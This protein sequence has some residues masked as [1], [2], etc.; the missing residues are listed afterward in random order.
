MKNILVT[1]G[2]VGANIDPVKI[3]TNK[4]RGGMMSELAKELA[5]YKGARVTYLCSKGSVE[6]I[7]PADGGIVCE[8]VH[9]DGFH[10]YMKKVCELAKDMDAVILGAAVANLIPVNWYQ[11]YLYSNARP[12]LVDPVPMPLKDKFPSHNYKPGDS[13]FMEW[14]IAPRVIDM[15]KEHLPKTGHLFGFKLLAGQPHDELIRAAYEVLLSSRATAVIANDPTKGLETKHIVTKER[16]VHTIGFKELDKWIWKMLEDEYYSTDTIPNLFGTAAEDDVNYAMGRLKSV[17]STYRSRFVEVEND[18]RFGTVAWRVNP[19]GSGFV[20]TGR[21]KREMD[22]LTYVWQVDHKNKVVRVQGLKA[23]LNAPLL[24]RIFD[25]QGPKVQGIVHVHGQVEGLPT[26]P[27]APPGTVRDSMTR[28]CD[29][30]FN[31]EGHGCFLLLDRDEM[32]I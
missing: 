32:V 28:P 24:D 11:G 10:D 6:P 27:Y 5:M 9:H 21:G 8:V 7:S 3:V 23:T 22:E 30:S 31:I 17:I 12:V 1:G 2:P 29:S 18:M 14:T 4:F 16:G 19:L 15:V 20:T 25:R 13:I 26:Y